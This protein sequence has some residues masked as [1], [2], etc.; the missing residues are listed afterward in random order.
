MYV[1]YGRWSKGFITRLGKVTNT[2][3]KCQMEIQQRK[4]HSWMVEERPQGNQ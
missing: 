3:M 1:D 4:R 2:R